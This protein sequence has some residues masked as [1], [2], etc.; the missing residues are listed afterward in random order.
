MH[1]KVFC[2]SAVWTSCEFARTIQSWCG[3]VA[4]KLCVAA[5][6]SSFVLFQIWLHQQ[7]NKSVHSCASEWPVS[8][9]HKCTELCSLVRISAVVLIGVHCASVHLCERECCAAVLLQSPSWTL[10]ASWKTPP[11]C[12]QSLGGWKGRGRRR[13]ERNYEQRRGEKE[14][15]RG[16][17]ASLL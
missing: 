10:A 15:K 2:S 17:V 16:P 12:E 11:G 8:F 13:K 9:T 4:A 1:T 7:T 6:S 3:A 5:L 14:W